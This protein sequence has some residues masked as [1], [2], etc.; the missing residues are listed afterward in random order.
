MI[1]FEMMACAIFEMINATYQ[2]ITSDVCQTM[3]YT[4]VISEDDK[5]AQKMSR[6]SFALFVITIFGNWVSL[7]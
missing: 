6:K 5:T 7:A 2:H 4:D 3:V 1:A